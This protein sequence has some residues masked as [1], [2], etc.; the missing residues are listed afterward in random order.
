MLA[1]V[2]K[3]VDIPN[4]YPAT[5]RLTLKAASQKLHAYLHKSQI[6]ALSTYL[7][8]S[9]NLLELRFI[10]LHTETGLLVA[11]IKGKRC[12]FVCTKITK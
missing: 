7:G 4:S 11:S 8:V 2:I 3:Q 10:E 5:V 12:A 6:I 1:K 9:V